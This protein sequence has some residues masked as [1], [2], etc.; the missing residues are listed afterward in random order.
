MTSATMS[1]AG[2]VNSGRPR[3]RYQTCADVARTAAV[4]RAVGNAT[5]GCEQRDGNGE[6]EKNFGES[7][8]RGRYRRRQEKQDGQ[9]AEH[10]LRD[11]RSERDDSKPP[12]PSAWL[13]EPEPRGEHDR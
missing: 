13:L 5:R 12:H 3:K 1:A 7:R 4:A 11:H 8:V 10:A 6:T 2:E 9:P